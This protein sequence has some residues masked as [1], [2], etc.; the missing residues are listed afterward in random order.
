MNKE[1]IIKVILSTL[2]GQEDTGFKGSTQHQRLL[3]MK[4]MKDSG[5]KIKMSGR[6]KVMHNYLP[7]APTENTKN[8]ID[9]YDS[10]HTE[11]SHMHGCPSLVGQQNITSSICSMST[12]KILV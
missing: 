5:R 3:K 9:V 7:L 4:V 2:Q 10:A 11:I 1:G 6:G 12:D 8:N